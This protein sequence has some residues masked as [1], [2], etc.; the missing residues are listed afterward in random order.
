M[1]FGY[2]LIFDHAI[3]QRDWRQLLE[4]I[5][6]LSTWWLIQ[7]GLSLA[8]EIQ[9]AKTGISAINDLR[10]S[11]YHS[12]ENLPIGGL[13]RNGSGDLISR[14]SVDLVNLERTAVHS[15]YV[16]FFSCFNVAASLALLFY[17][18]WRLALLA[19]SGMLLSTI[20]PRRF[21]GK[22]EQKSYERKTYEGHLGSFV[23]ETLG[24]FDI[25][26]AFN[27]WDAKKKE[28][29]QKLETFKTRASFSYFLS[30][31]VGRL[32]G[33]SAALLQILIMAFGAFLVIEGTITIG[34]LV[35]FLAL[36]QNMVAGASH[37]AGVVPDLL[38]ASGAMRRVQEYL[39]DVETK[40]QEKSTIRL[41][42]LRET[43]R[44][45]EVGFRYDTGK[46]VLEQVDFEIRCGESVAIV[47]PSGSGKSTILKLLLRFHD[48]QV[49]GI[50]WDG[51]DLRHFSKTSLRERVSIVPQDSVLFDTSL[52]ENIRIGRLDATDYEIVE[53]AKLAELHELVA[54]LPQGYDTR[55]GERGSLLSGGQ[56]Q[57]VAIA[58][59]IL[60]DPALL[61]LDEA[62]SALDPVTERAV[63]ETL[64]R[65]ARNRT[66]ISVTHRL[67]TVKKMDR[68]LVM[69][70]GRVAQQGTHE[71]L[72]NQTGL[73]AELWRKQ[74]GFTVSNDGFRAECAPHRLKLIP[75]FESL[76][77]QQLKKIS[78]LLV[79]EFF[80]QDRMVFSKGDIGGKFYIVVNGRVDISGI[81]TDRGLLESAV[82]E[83]GDFFGELALLDETT[84]NATVTTLMPTLFLTLTQHD[85]K[86][87]MTEIPA[88]QSAIEKVARSRRP[89]QFPEP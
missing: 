5:G 22:A 41:P 14:F 60:R 81:E 27:L 32:G 13:G 70:H 1:P 86:N 51:S 47:G 73:Y 12:L 42:R 50:K 76:D 83:S 29:D 17:I 88:L 21:S 58:R 25:I 87:L 7:A 56:R 59:A 26:H 63:N 66:L 28:F 67:T 71:T 39:H 68:I 57:R 24:T 6:V 48:P 79:S 36:L 10:A 18:D 78:E 74:A 40:D 8:Q 64:S 62:T 72:L 61:V 46:A 43:L 34:H 20:A 45:E 35:G 19:L 53:A 54:K 89:H 2:Q 77:F 9:A 52:S 37:L 49:G 16:F 31:L 30:G 11:M 75:L 15:L 82:L 38:Q 44:F 80:P 33:Q 23:Q 85:F 69:R 4:I 65:V 84:R 3:P 55:V